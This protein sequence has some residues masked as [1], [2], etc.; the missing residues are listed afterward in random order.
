MSGL[1]NSNIQTTYTPSGTIKNQYVREQPNR[2]FGSQKAKQFGIIFE[3]ITD[4]K[5]YKIVYEEVPDASHVIYSSGS[6][7]NEG[8]VTSVIRLNSL[9]FANGHADI[10]L[11][12]GETL[13]FRGLYLYSVSAPQISNQ[14]STIHFKMVTVGYENTG[15]PEI[16]VM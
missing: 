6:I 15:M 10:T 7:K 8:T 2:E 9:G 16:E 14:S 1:L 13:K 4:F 12:A 11:A 5:E 3:A